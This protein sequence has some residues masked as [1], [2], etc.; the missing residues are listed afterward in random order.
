MYTISHDYYA[1]LGVTKDT[2]LNEIKRQY[3]RLIRDHHPDQYN[4][5]K[6]K[7]E[8]SGDEILLKVLEEKIKEAEEFCKLLN[9]ALEVLTDTDKRKQ[10]DIKMAES[11]VEEPK[12]VVSRNIVSFGAL[13][14]GEKKHSIFTINNEG[15][16]PAH[17]HLEWEDEEPVWGYFR[18]YE[19]K[20]TSFPI[21]VVVSVDLEGVPPGPK[22]EKIVI[23]TDEGIVQ[24]VDV[25]L[26]VVETVA[27]APGSVPDP[28]ITGPV[29]GA[30]AP[31]HPPKPAPKSSVPVFILVSLI[32]FFGCLVAVAVGYSVYNGSQQN[33]FT[34]TTQT[35]DL[36]T[37]RAL[38]ERAKSTLVYSTQVA[39]VQQTQ[40]QSQANDLATQ[41]MLVNLKAERD[42][43]R[44]AIVISEIVLLR[45]KDVELV[46]CER[47]WGGCD[48]VRY[49]NFKVS[50]TGTKPIYINFYSNCDIP[51]DSY[52]FE[53]HDS[54]TVHCEIPGLYPEPEK[55]RIGATIET[56]NETYDYWTIYPYTGVIEH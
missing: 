35:A 28:P 10:Y 31:T 40:Q 51:V 17:L 37:S 50:N 44:K 46:H 20:E 19:S 48:E 47:S 53:P 18:F 45:R 34:Q 41:E 5:L 23:M 27:P 54:I 1:V 36:A 16:P 26:T 22:N 14:N 2:P 33:Q 55:F 11:R 24:T 38:V 29:T 43:Y 32:L 49:M 13:E 7:Y 56:T 52:T 42:Q 12:I 4:G 9:E 30:T 21:K 39:R 3:K 8:Q 25:F 15:G 6:S